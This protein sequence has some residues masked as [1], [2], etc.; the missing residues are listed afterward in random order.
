M[1]NERI[2]VLGGSGFIG[3]HLCAQ[4]VAAGYQVTVPSRSRDRARRLF[5]LP[6][7]DVV[8]ANIHDPGRLATLMRGHHAVINLVAQLHDRR[9][10]PYGNGFKLAH[11]DLVA[12]IGR[13]AGDQRVA[14]VIHLSA[15]GVDR[16]VGAEFTLPSMYLRSK[17]AGEL[18]L[19]SLRGLPWTI[20]RPSVVFGPD[21]RLLN[22]FATLQRRLP[23][24]ALGGADAKLQP[25]YVGDVVK[26]VMACLFKH[27]H[28]GKIYEIAG[29][30]VFTLRELVWLAGAISG[31]SRPVIGLPGP[32]A[33]LLALAMEWLPG[34]TL[35]SRDNLDSLKRANV[36]SQP[37][38]VELGFTPR[39]LALLAPQWL[40]PQS[41]PL[42]L[43]RA[44]GSR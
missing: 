31:H 44:R 35:L 4:L 27:E 26:A 24:I 29:P 40:A 3:G 1:A 36:L 41:D 43:F 19:N 25:I 17:A 14:H 11:V 30:D 32:L 6:G 13:I 9:A 22:L 18:A 38:P 34:P 10:K 15:L 21:D 8:T 5:L 37:F 28:H 7:L 42:A 2:L 20:L 39:S 33:R 12:Q 16:L 23:L